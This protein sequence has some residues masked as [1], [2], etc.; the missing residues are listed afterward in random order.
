[1]PGSNT[2][3]T[4]SSK[5]LRHLLAEL[6]EGRPLLCPRCQ[7]ELAVEAPVQSDDVLIHETYCPSCRHCAILRSSAR[8]RS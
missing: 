4:Y 8:G 5:E 1:M 6:E 7:T 3:V 2:P